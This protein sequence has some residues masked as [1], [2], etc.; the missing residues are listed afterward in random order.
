MLL[1]VLDT[2]KT[3]L[4]GPSREIAAQIAASAPERVLVMVDACQLRCPADR[5]RAD[6]DGGFMV[7]I[8]GSKFAGGPPLSGA[9][10]LPEAIATHLRSAPLP[11]EGLAD[12]SA[13][14]DWP[15]RAAGDLR[16]GHD[17]HGQPGAGPALDA[18]RWLSSGASPRSTRACSS[19]SSPG[20]S[21]RCA[22]APA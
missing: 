10:L 14:L 7:L 1:H 2:S 12:Y 11:P 3:G 16:Q 6:L 13:R 20:S 18:R 22:C 21:A 5:L 9:L 8:T 19:G 17:D 4:A 15:E